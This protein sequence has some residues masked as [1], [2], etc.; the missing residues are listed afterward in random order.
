MV[1]PSLNNI[2]TNALREITK[3]GSGHAANALSQL[4]KQQ[5]MIHI[6]EI[7]IAKLSQI[8]EIVGG[9]EISVAAVYF[10]IF[11]D[12]QGNILLIFPEKSAEAL[13]SQLLKKKKQ[14]GILATV[15]GESALKEVG[16]I[17]SGSF[18]NAFGSMVGLTLIPS[19]PY[20]IWDTAGTV[21]DYTSI[22]HGQKGDLTLMLRT[23]LK[24][25][26]EDIQGHFF[27]LPSPQSLSIILKAVG[28]RQK[29]RKEPGKS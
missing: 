24:T 23:Q 11:G 17:L 5:V 9:T 7:K 15:E 20:F 22:T 12:A 13:S 25:K 6:T 14:E 8:L 4:V 10:Q 19:I 21:M 29:S 28:Q 16:N 1:F 26:K 27:L 2:Q 3:I 18:L